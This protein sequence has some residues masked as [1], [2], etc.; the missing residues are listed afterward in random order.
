VAK[1]K[2]LKQTIKLAKDLRL[3]GKTIGLITGCFDIVHIDHIELFRFAKKHVDILIIGLENDQN[4]RLAKGAGRPI[5]NFNQRSAVLAELRSVDYIFKIEDIVDFGSP[6]A[7]EIY[8]A[9][10]QKIKPNYLITNIKADTYW[11]KKD[12]NAKALGIKLLKHKR[13]VNSSSTSILEKL[14]KS[15]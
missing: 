2:T 8:K 12:R 13:K 5:H 9:I 11:R 3:Q 6:H 7:N 14:Q 10:Y 4:I 15:E 1:V